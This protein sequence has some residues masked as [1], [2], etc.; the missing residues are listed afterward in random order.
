MEDICSVVLTQGSIYPKRKEE[1]RVWGTGFSPTNEEYQIK[2][3][4]FWPVKLQNIL[5]SYSWGHPD[6]LVMDA[7]IFWCVITLILW[8]VMH[9]DMPNWR[10]VIDDNSWSRG[11]QRRKRDESCR[12]MKLAEL[13]INYRILINW[14]CIW[15]WS[16]T[17]LLEFGS[18]IKFTYDWLQ[19]A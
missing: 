18:L 11:I 13:Q 3:G 9:I 12:S 17:L 6:T 14:I 1:V 7:R 2:N 16:L 15:I 5:C 19:F 4:C 10:K 8:Q